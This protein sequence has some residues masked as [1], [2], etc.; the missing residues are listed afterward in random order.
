MSLELVIRWEDGQTG[1]LEHG[2]MLI[3]HL[4]EIDVAAESAGLRTLAS[5]ADDRDIPD[6]FDGDPEELAE[7]LGPNPI[8]HTPAEA[9]D[10][11][12]Q[13]SEHAS[14]SAADGLRELATVLRRDSRAFQLDVLM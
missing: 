14:G 4:E 5:Y 8:W 9:S 3:A 12:K 10:Q 7:L 1:S 2:E 11:L 6:D 13:L